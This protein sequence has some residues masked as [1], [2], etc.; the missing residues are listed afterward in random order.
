M[1]Q[2]INLNQSKFDLEELKR[3]IPEDYLIVFFCPVEWIDEVG[4]SISK[5]YKNSIGCS[6][7]KDITRNSC[8]YYSISFLGIKIEAVELLLLKDVSKKI[9]TYYKEIGSLSKIY[10]K[11][12]SILLEFTDGLSLAEESILT[13]ITNE[14]QD[15]PLVGGSAAD[16][17]SFTQTKVC[18]NG[19]SASDASALCMLTTPMEIEYYCENIYEPTDVLGIITDSELFERKINKIDGIPAT[20]FYCKSLNISKNDMKK[21]FIHHPFARLIGDNYFITSLMNADENS[22]NIYCRCFEDS[23]I[24]ICNS[25]DYKQLWKDNSKKYSNKYLGGIFMNCI[26]RTQLFENDNTIKEFQKYLNLFGDYICMTAYG[27]QYCDSH[28]N[29]TMTYCLFKE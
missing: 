22:I 21:E 3:T 28:A 11:N 15:I 17:G 7:Y 20:D 25:I 13:V 29:Q 23:Y 27:E 26:F 18:I 10:K 6:S 14:L 12:H 19:V 16:N 9:I 2:L 1:K 8:E 5:V 24:S 4:Y